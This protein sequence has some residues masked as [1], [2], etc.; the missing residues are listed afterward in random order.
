MVVGLGKKEGREFDSEE[1]VDWGRE[2]V[3]KAA[4]SGVRAAAELKAGE[5]QIKTFGEKNKFFTWG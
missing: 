3:R 5:V 1:G 4:A 2:V